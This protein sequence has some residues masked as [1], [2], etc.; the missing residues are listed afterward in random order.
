MNRQG[1]PIRLLVSDVDG[2]LLTPD[3]GLTPA[4]LLALR[5]L[6]AAGVSFTIASARPPRGL[7]S[8]IDALGI[9]V[10]FGAFNGGLIVDPDLTVLQERALPADLVGEL[11]DLLRERVDMVWVYRG[12]DWYASRSVGRHLQHERDVLGFSP[13]PLGEAGVLDEGVIKLVAVSDRRRD[14]HALR[15]ELVARFPGRLAVT[16]SQTHSLEITHPAANKGAVV[17][18]AGEWLDVGRAETATI[19]DMPNDIAM[20]ERSGLAIAMGN[21]DARAV[22]AADWTTTTNDRDGFA[23]A[24]REYVLARSPWSDDSTR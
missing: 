16:S 11:V 14:L 10:P 13:R 19:G 8:L 12:D 3:K 18:F 22:A 24:V 5:D 20:F 1:P 4:A 9:D 6:R 2:T 17:R 23:R 21:A 7:A 15:E